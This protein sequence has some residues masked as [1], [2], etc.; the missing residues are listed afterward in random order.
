MNKIR[1]TGTL[2]ESMSEV[3]EL[4]V[5]HGASNLSTRRFLRDIGAFTSTEI[6]HLME[7]LQVAKRKT[8]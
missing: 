4:Y 5:R 6:F 2:E 7:L 8:I 1:R 3:F